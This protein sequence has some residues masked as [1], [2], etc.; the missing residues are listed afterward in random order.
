MSCLAGPVSRDGSG[1]AAVPPRSEREGSTA[2]ICYSGRQLDLDLFRE[3]YY[4]GDVSVLI[5][6]MILL[7]TKSWE[8]Y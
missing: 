2:A 8:Y 4:P 6:E 7:W 5:L 3:S 1:N